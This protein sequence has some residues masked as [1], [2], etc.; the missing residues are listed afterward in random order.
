M[1]LDPNNYRTVYIGDEK[2][3]LAPKPTGRDLT[4]EF[5]RRTISVRGGEFYPTARPNTRIRYAPVP[6]KSQM[7]GMLG[8]IHSIKKALKKA[9]EEETGIKMREWTPGRPTDLSE[10]GRT[11]RYG[12]ET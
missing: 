12:F 2:Y 8:R 4:L 5:P 7:A 11:D 6:S 3:A 9:K 1:G 10:Y